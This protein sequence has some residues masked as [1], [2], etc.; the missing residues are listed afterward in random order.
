MNQKELELA[1]DYLRNNV[2][3]IL[4]KMTVDLLISK[5]KDVV[6]YLIKWINE[7]GTD[8]EK[9]F[10]RKMKNRPDGVE[11]SDSSEEDE[12]LLPL[13]KHNVERKKR[14]SVSAEVYGQYNPKENFEPVMHPKTDTEKI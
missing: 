2:T 7:K 10:Q 13:P 5:P 14:K 11:T 1:Q 12:E 9:E 4:E 3:G 8:V 6:P